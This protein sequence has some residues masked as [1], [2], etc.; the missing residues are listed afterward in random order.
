MFSFQGL[1]LNPD[2]DNQ[3]T[4]FSRGSVFLDLDSVDLEEFANRKM[5]K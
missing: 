5:Q 2:S 1:F 3:V 4:T